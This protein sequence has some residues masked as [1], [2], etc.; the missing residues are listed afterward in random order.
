VVHQLMKL[1]GELTTPQLM[2]TACYEMLHKAMELA[3]SCEYD[4]NLRVP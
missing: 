2:K 4:M 3:R 1:G